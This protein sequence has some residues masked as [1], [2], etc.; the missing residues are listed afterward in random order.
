MPGENLHTNNDTNIILPLEH[1]HLASKNKHVTENNKLPKDTS[2]KLSTP[3]ISNK[4][5]ES[6]DLAETEQLSHNNQ[7]SPD[8]DVLGSQNE[9][10][11]TFALPKLL[12]RDQQNDYDDHGRS[13]HDSSDNSYYSS[14]NEYVPLDTSSSTSNASSEFVTQLDETCGTLDVQK[15]TQ[16]D[17][18]MDTSLIHENYAE[19]HFFFVFKSKF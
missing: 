1:Q 7:L 12:N 2:F 9:L 15:S 10:E 5:H 18:K 8:R 3:L 17:K 14:G 19:V 6:S 16:K 13:I 4:D 11:T